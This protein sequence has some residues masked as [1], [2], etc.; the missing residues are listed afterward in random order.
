M[1]ERNTCDA[2]MRGIVVPPGR[3]LG[4]PAGIGTGWRSASVDFV[5]IVLT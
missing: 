5:T 3:K 1:V 2:D 4:I